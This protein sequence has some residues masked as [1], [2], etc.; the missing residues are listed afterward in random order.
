ML[1]PMSGLIDNLVAAAERRSSAA[2]AAGNS[3]QWTA[4]FAATLAAL[5]AD[6]EGLVAEP[7]TVHPLTT[8]AEVF[9]LDEIDAALLWLAAAV[10]LDA[11]IGLAYAL[12]RGLAGA[13]RPSVAL[14]LELLAVPTA[15][16]ES[17]ARLGPD[18][19]LRRSRL[20]E[21]SDSEPWLGRVLSVAHSVTAVLAGGTPCDPVVARLRTPV[22][23]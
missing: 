14:A 9:G 17:F 13:V 11:N 22:L 10:D 12:L 15:T 4:E 3:W 7:D 19:A 2:Q 21:V 16:P 6:Y 18:G 5:Q 8:I 20:L 23:P 1:H